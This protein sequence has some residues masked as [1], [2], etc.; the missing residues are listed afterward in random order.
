MTRKGKQVR[1]KAIK[2]VAPLLKEFAEHFPIEKL[3]RQTRQL[4]EVRQYIDE[5]RYK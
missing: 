5:Y 4:A 3:R 2:A 1:N